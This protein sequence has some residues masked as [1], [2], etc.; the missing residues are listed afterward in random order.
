MAA[1]GQPFTIVESLVRPW[2]CLLAWDVYWEKQPN[3]YYIQ[4][5]KKSKNT[6]LREEHCPQVTNKYQ[7]TYFLSFIVVSPLL[8]VKSHK[9]RSKK[10]CE[11]NE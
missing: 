10:P 5:K 4:K 1:E 7:L 3:S 6:N 11:L 8:R 2:V 9:R